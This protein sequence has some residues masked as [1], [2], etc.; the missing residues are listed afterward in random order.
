MNPAAYFQVAIDGPAAAGK[1]TVAALLAARIGGHYIST[2]ALYR[3]AAWFC[4]SHSVTPGTST[5]SA[6]VELLPQCGLRYCIEGGEAV[7]HLNGRPVDNAALRT[8]Q[9]AAVVSQT[10]RIPEVRQRLL[11]VQRS[12]RELGIVIMEGRDIG[13]VIFPDARFKFF[14]TATPME[15]ARRRLA[16]PG[17]T[18]SGATLESIAAAIAERDR[19][20]STRAVAP[21][22]PAPD[23]VTVVTDGLNAGEVADKLAAVIHAGLGGGTQ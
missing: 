16:Q 14:V 11:E 5:D 10:A 8:P 6:V 3:A 15:R 23:A 19:I 7:L 13:T 2:G 12:C 1:S 18:A 20:D 22:R 4:L 21:L 9:V 17:E